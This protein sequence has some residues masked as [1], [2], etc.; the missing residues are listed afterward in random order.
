MCSAL[1]V[2]ISGRGVAGKDAGIK[3]TWRYWQRPQAGITASKADRQ[4]L[5]L[6][7]LL[8]N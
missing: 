2:V 5:C 4:R 1:G 7:V 8:N 3:L 6:Q